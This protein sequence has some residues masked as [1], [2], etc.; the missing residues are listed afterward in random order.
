MKSNR[1]ATK[2]MKT[3]AIKKVRL[4]KSKKLH[5]CDSFLDYEDSSQILGIFINHKL[6]FHDHIANV[7]RKLSKLRELCYHIRD[8]LTY[9]QFLNFSMVYVKPVIQYCIL[10]YGCTTIST[11]T[12]IY[13][14]QC[15]ILKL[16][17]IELILIRY[18]ICSMAK[19]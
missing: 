17:A 16:L 8:K 2:V 13:I 3:K 14:M 18:L 19:S 7:C 9:T 4:N 6:V 11:L 15:K 10:V 1:V 12:S 5:F